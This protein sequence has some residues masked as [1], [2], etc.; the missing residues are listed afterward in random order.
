MKVVL[1]LTHEKRTVIHCKELVISPDDDLE[2]SQDAHL[3]IESGFP[4]FL[5]VTER[6]TDGGT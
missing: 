5:K 1:T 3:H 4:G 2:E 6:I